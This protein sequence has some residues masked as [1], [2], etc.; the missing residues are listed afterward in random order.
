[1]SMEK[2]KKDTRNSTAIQ[3]DTMGSV[4]AW[5]NDAPTGIEGIGAIIA[6]LPPIENR[7]PEQQQI[8]TAFADLFRQAGRINAAADIAGIDYTAER[9][10]F[11]NNAG[12]TGSIRTRISY[13][14]ALSRLEVWAAREKRNI[15]TLTPAQA[16][17]FIYSLRGRA[18]AS[19]RLDVSACSSFFAWLERRHAGITNPFRGTRARPGKKDVR[20]TEIPEAANVENLLQ[21]MPPKIAAAAAVMAFRG[22]RA[23]ALASLSITGGHFTARS[24]GKDIRGKMPVSVLDT[25]KKAGLPLRAPFAEMMKT[26]NPDQAANTLEKRIIYYS[27][28]LYKAGIIPA[29]YSAHDLRHFY[30][31]TEYRKDQDIDRLCKLLGHASIQVT[32]TYLKERGEIE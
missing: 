19:V 21:S 10:T 11:L 28:K 29:V 14:A 2:M 18:P 32:S 7:S 31:V 12:K 30:A 26:E 3:G 4:M 9:E 17:D 8:F 27:R 23:G 5:I 15:L 13:R 6:S 22:L 24:K 25:I 20:K 1:M 16:D